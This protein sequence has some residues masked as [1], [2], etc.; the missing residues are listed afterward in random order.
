MSPRS[1]R[2]R[3][4]LI[5][6]LGLVSAESHRLRA[7]SGDDQ[8]ARAVLVPA[9]RR[10]AAHR[11]QLRSGQV[12]RGQLRPRQVTRR[13]GQLRSGQLRSGHTEIRAG[14][15]PRG[16]ARPG[17][18]SSSSG[19]VSSGVRGH[20][21]QVRSGQVGS[22]Q[23]RSDQVTQ[24]RLAQVSEDIQVRLRQVRQVA[25]N[26]IPIVIET[27]RWNSVTNM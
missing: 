24:V 23:I 19:Q 14:Q 20:T 18:V 7:S 26:D 12:T 21:G 3:P 27:Y 4:P 13:S 2:R 22:G 17:E 6:S 10:T 11:G 5:D 9:A 15:V 16:H 25:Q 8:P 1:G